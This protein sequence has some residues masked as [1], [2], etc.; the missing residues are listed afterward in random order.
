MVFTHVLFLGHGLARQMC[1][2]LQG[3]SS[4]RGGCHKR[5]AGVSG[6]DNHYAESW[7]SVTSLGRL[8]HHEKSVSPSNDGAFGGLISLH[9]LAANLIRYP[10]SSLLKSANK[11]CLIE[12]CVIQRLEDRLTRRRQSGAISAAA[13]QSL[14]LAPQLRDFLHAWGQRSATSPG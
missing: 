7:D 10:P 12:P 1:P 2:L 5:C 11:S 13:E 3:A 9:L 6:G 4:V 14:S 8:P